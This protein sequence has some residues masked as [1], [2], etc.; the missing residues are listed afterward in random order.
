MNNTK[1]PL[2][3]ASITCFDCGSTFRGKDLK[4]AM[5]QAMSAGWG[6]EQRRAP[7]GWGWFW[8]CKADRRPK[9]S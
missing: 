3:E 9:Q 6:K 7:D 1:T 2:A 8:I 5:V 4:D